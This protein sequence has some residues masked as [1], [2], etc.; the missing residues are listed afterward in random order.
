[1]NN[2]YINVL[3]Y[4]NNNILYEKLNSIFL[5]ESI[6]MIYISKIE[7]YKKAI[8]NDRIY[9]VIID[10]SIPE[11][12]QAVLLSKSN[13][14]FRPIIILG[15]CERKKFLQMGVNVFINYKTIADEIL[16]QSLNL[17]TLYQAKKNSK[18]QNDVL[19]TLSIALEVRDFHTHGHGERLAIFAST[20]YDKLGFKD[21]EEREALKSAATI[22]DVG[23]IG[24]PDEI[25]KSF[26]KL[27]PEQFDIIKNHP[28]DGVKICLKVVS[29]LRVIDIIQ[30]H[31]EKLDGSGY[32]HG[33][34]GGEIE[35]VVQITTLCD[36][37][38]AL[39]S[40]RSYRTRNTPEEALKIMETAFVNTNKINKDYYNKF[41]ELILNNTF[42]NLKYL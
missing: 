8:E 14:L 5:K 11:A 4:D 41:K 28:D 38:D 23:K 1:M 30:H 32:P 16:T 13:D 15:N 21:F 34:R 33:L 22:H 6:N 29:D 17:I 19:K 9:L 7:D 42:S 26:D 39:T 12:Y 24:T 40:D 36:I 37:Y 27:S 3:I 25:L 2:H 18:S 20:L 35:P 10:C 31:H